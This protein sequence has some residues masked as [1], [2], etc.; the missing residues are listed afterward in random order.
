MF[1]KFE[2][3]NTDEDKIHSLVH[4]AASYGESKKNIYMQIKLL[5]QKQQTA[6]KQ[7]YL[8]SNLFPPCT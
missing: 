8:V 4:I 2:V 6:I 3:L 5:E 7:P 1:L